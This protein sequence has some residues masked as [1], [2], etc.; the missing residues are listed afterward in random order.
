MFLI[1]VL[2]RPCDVRGN[3]EVPRMH[4]RHEDR[5]ILSSRY[6]RGVTPEHED[7]SDENLANLHGAWGHR[8]RHSYAQYSLQFLWA[9]AQDE[10]Q[11]DIA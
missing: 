5:P 3:S 8:Y 2:Y 11:I 9:N 7:T 6:H 1:A 10:I 4:S